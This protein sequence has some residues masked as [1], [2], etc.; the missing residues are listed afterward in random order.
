MEHLI[1]A[2]VFLL[3]LGTIVRRRWSST[4]GTTALLLLICDG[5]LTLAWT[6]NL[7]EGALV[8]L[9]L[10]SVIVFVQV[11]AS[12]PLRRTI[13]RFSFL[14]GLV[15][16]SAV[17][18]ARAD[19][20]T[21]D[22]FRFLF[23]AGIDPNQFAVQAAIAVVILAS[24][25]A[26]DPKGRASHRIR[27]SL[28]LAFIVALSGAVILSGSRT[29]VLAAAAG[30][31]V[32][33]L[34]AR[35]DSGQLRLRRRRLAWLPALALLV[36][37][38]APSLMNSNSATLLER[39]EAG[40]VR[41]DLDGRDMVWRAGARYFAS[42]TRIIVIGG[43]LGSFDESAVSY[44]S[45]PLYKVALHMAAVNPSRVDPYFASHNDLLRI[46][47]DLGVVGLALF[48]TFYAQAALGCIGIAAKGDASTLPLALLVTLL[49]GGMAIDLVS[50]PV[51]PIVLALV[52]APSANVREGVPETA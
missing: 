4:P 33:L 42:S 38:V 19:S 45:A 51:Y 47:C 37:L 52:L 28:L 21:V 27:S 6:I 13:A 36:V 20:P 26:A 9:N 8:L 46:A 39:Y 25:A 44:L 2:S 18:I 31:S 29:G 35:S 1:V 11:L 40:F 14:G 3:T 24:M 43:G 15:I 12:N 10:A 48:V 50:F 23:P 41:G 32:V 30:C 17:G 22:D 49:V 34:L 7:K 5:A 16:M